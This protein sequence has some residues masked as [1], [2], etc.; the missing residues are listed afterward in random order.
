M[1]SPAGSGDAASCICGSNEYKDGDVCKDCP[2][3][4]ISQAGSRYQAQCVCPAN[5]YMGYGGM[6]YGGERE[7]ER[8]EGKG[9]KERR[10]HQGNHSIISCASYLLD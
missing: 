3:G 10:V 6:G 1:T 2:T 4:M 5:S 8:E 9:Q 7:T